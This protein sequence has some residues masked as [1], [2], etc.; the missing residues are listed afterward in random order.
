MQNEMLSTEQFLNYDTS[1][2][3]S[4]GT[5]QIRLPSVLMFSI[6]ARRFMHCAF[7]G[8]RFNTDN[9]SIERSLKNDETSFYR[10]I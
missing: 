1:N 4:I 6:P 9:F 5:V 8:I 7:M 3:K 10:C 2:R